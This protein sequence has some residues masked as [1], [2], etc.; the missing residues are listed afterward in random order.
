MTS[1]IGIIFFLAGTGASAGTSA[2]SV[3]GDEWE[4]VDALQRSLS[5]KA[6]CVPRAGA[7]ECPGKSLLCIELQK[8]RKMENGS[9][10]RRLTALL[11]ERHLLPL[12]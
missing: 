5:H 9:M 12:T 8:R 4:R 6:D 3:I 10:R 11:A 2:A 1:A 7:D